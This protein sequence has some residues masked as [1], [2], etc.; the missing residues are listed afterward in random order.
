MK[1]ILK[2]ALL[3]LVPVILSGCKDDDF[4][5]SIF[6][7]DTIVRNEFDQWLLDNFAYPYNIEVKY[8]LDHNETEME[9]ALAP[10]DFD[11]A[12]GLAKMIKFL[13]L[14]VYDEVAA[15]SF[16][17][18]YAPKVIQMVGSGAYDYNGT[19]KLGTAEGG[20]KVTLYCVNDLDLTNPDINMLNDYYFH[21][22]HHE[23]AHIL[24]Q[25]IAYNPL[26]DKISEGDYIGGDWYKLTNQDAY[27]KGFVSKYS[28]DSPRED[29]VEIISFYITETAEAWDARVASMAEYGQQQ[30]NKKLTIIKDYMS[31]TWGID[32]DQ[33]RRSVLR[34]QGEIKYID[35]TKL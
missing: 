12:Q 5:D 8:H 6:K 13:W 21:T 22:M 16:M 20:L 1:K 31:R 18:I 30:M 35:F 2:Y 26:F 14:E 32:M 23:F 29:F 9:Y 19:F 4:T 33:L 10:A 27:D 34:R 7:D 24:H 28:M 25:T 3:L 15:P 17:R 11:K